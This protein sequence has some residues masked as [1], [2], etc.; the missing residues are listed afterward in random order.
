MKAEKKT[1]QSVSW[2]V[3]LSLLDSFSS[4]IDE[5]PSDENIAPEHVVIEVF[6]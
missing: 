1:I 3:F 5:P 6:G 4:L 2:I